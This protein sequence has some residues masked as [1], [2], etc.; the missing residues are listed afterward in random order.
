MRSV[1]FKQG[2][3]FLSAVDYGCKEQIVSDKLPLLSLS[4][5]ERSWSAAGLHLFRSSSRSLPLKRQDN[6]T[7][8]EINLISSSHPGTNFPFEGWKVID[9]LNCVLKKGRNAHRG[10]H[11]QAAARG[12][13]ELITL[14][15]FL[16]RKAGQ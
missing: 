11:F 5:R 16:L 7:A 6:N 9:G 2:G 14:G 8:T 13:H 1:L 10:D 12:V 3:R 4:H 15:E